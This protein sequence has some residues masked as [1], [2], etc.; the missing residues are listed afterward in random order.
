MAASKST[1]PPPTAEEVLAVW[2]SRVPRHATE[3]DSLYRLLNDRTLQAF[4]SWL[5][6]P[7]ATLGRQHERCPLELRERMLD[8]F[9]HYMNIA[10]AQPMRYWVGLGDITATKEWDL[11][12]A[13]LFVR[14]IIF[15]FSLVY[16]RQRCLDT[17][18][19]APWL[20]RGLPST[21]RVPTFNPLHGCITTIVRLLCVVSD[22]VDVVASLTLMALATCHRI[23]TDIL[24]GRTPDILLPREQ[25]N[26]PDPANKERTVA[27]LHVMRNTLQLFINQASDMTT[28]TV[29]LL[30]HDDKGQDAL[31]RLPPKALVKGSASS[32]SAHD[33]TP[34]PYASKE[35]P[36]YITTAEWYKVGCD[37]Q[38]AYRAASEKQHGRDDCTEWRTHW[39]PLGLQWLRKLNPN[40]GLQTY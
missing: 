32:A 17:E 1:P 16:A 11:P 18:P 24:E 6:K 21:D 35:R 36:K 3:L 26:N 20:G 19:T 30:D 12:Q 27:R 7:Q 13:I 25:I 23:V 4:F 2:G 14:A 31:L 29:L 9:Q 39:T 5:A 22:P 10:M 37:F 33:G 15:R 8:L 38:A 40:L 28:L 34:V